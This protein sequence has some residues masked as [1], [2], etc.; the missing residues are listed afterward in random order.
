[1]AATFD[2]QSGFDIGDAMQELLTAPERNPYPSLS[3]TLYDHMWRRIVNLEFPPG[4]RLS[5]E[6]LA[7]EFGVS[8]TPIR[9][10]LQRLSQVGLVQVNSRRGFSIPTF[11]R[12]D[13]NDLYDLR[14]GLELYATRKATPLVTDEEIAAQRERQR[15]A[16]A[17][18]GADPHGFEAFYRADLL[19]HDLVQRRGGNRRTMQVLADVMAQLSIISH[20]T[21]Q[22]AERRLDAIAE[23]TRI[24]DAFARRD[25]DAAV[26]AMEAHIQGVK[27]RAL[28]DFFPEEE[29][30]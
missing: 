21:S 23:H 10:A 3:D 19:L 12:E 27:N 17:A 15:A 13:V 9:E 24:L 14:T 6:E 26:K 30:A 18:A 22:I 20:R 5:D 25:P 4:S 2:N 29:P 1:M 8:R 28:A 7:R 16:T 11:T